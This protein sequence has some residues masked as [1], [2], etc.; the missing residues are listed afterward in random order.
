MGSTTKS[1]GF[2]NL[3]TV[4]ARLTQMTKNRNLWRTVAW[5]AILILGIVAVV[6]WP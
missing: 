3:A 1:N 4:E 2:F 5:V 6:V